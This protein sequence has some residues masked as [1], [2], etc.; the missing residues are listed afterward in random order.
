MRLNR[1]EWIG[2]FAAFGGVFLAAAAPTI[3]PDIFW[4][5]RAARMTLESGSVPAA[6]TLSFTAAGARWVN[7]EWLGQVVAYGM[8]RLFGLQGVSLLFAAVTTSAFVALAARARFAGAHPI[9]IGYGLAAALLTISG[10]LGARMQMFTLALT[11]I[12][13]LLLDRH[14]RSR[15][16]AWLVP[17][18]LLM[19]LW[20]NLHG[21]VIL[22]LVVQC[23][24]ATGAALERRPRQAMHLLAAAAVSLGAAIINPQ[25]LHQLTYPLKFFA[26]NEFST[27][28]LESEPPFW[29]HP[30]VVTWLVLLLLVI[31]L[32]LRARRS[33]EVT[34]LLLVGAFTVLAMQQVRHV[35]LWAIAIIPILLGQISANVR[36]RRTEPT[37][38][39][40]ARQ[41]EWAILLLIVIGYTPIAIRYLGPA[42]LA[43]EESRSYPPRALEPLRR[44]SAE[45]IFA[46][47]HWGGYV[48]WNA[49]EARVFIDGRADT[50][51]DPSI[52]LEYLAIV[53]ASPEW[54]ERLDRWSVDALLLDT[55]AE[56]AREVESSPHWRVV[57]RDSKSVA[58]VRA[59]GAKVAADGGES[60]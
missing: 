21:G 51:Y 29:G 39:P 46:S 8:Y 11:G 57:Y 37:G 13:L 43:A 7:H 1:L 41:L 18:P 17:I 54:Q 56:L 27:A 38:R 33:V 40:R 36:F 9:L 16:W 28:I 48:V 24:Y 22:G 52:L 19:L 10:S 30:A 59:P 4:H 50:V 12:L 5:L 32:A 3:D 49:P 58:A 35:S 15:R 44:A 26:G 47:Y 2:A 55:D 31:S 53:S 6:D 23:V 60:G 42:K 34:D 45:R 14:R 20:S 25:G